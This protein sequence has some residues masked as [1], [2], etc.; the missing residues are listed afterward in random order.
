MC[1]NLIDEGLGEQ[2]GRLILEPLSASSTVYDTLALVI[3]ID[4]FDEC[5]SQNGARMLLILLHQMNDL[6][7]IQ[8]RALLSP[9]DLS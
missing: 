4:A 1:S 6:T 2:W 5:A 7:N 3:V 8:L 9:A